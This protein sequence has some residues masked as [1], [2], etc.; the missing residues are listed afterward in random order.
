M[1]ISAYLTDH[2]G[3][4]VLLIGMG[5]LLH[6][7]IHLERRM[8][9]RMSTTCA[10]LF[11]YSV[12]CYVETYL[13]NQIDYS[14]WRPILSAVNYSLVTFVLVNI[15]LIVC[16]SQRLYLYIPA[17]L[18]SILCFVSIPTGI[19]FYISPDNHFGRGTLGYLTYFINALYLLYLIFSMFR[20]S[21]NTREDYPL[22]LFMAVTSVLC[23]IMPL[24]IESASQHWFNISIAIDVLLYYVFLLQQFTKRD[25]LTKLLNRQSYYSDSEKYD[26]EITS[27]VAIDMDGLKEI[28]DTEGHVAGDTALKALADCFMKATKRGQRAY[29][30]GGDEY[31]ILCLDTMEDAV[32]EL[33]ERIRN[34]VVKTPYTCSIGYAMKDGETSIDKLYQLADIKLYDE[35]KL[36]YERTGKI[37]R[38][39]K[40]P[41][42]TE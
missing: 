24:F 7:D 23:L 14:I 10:L 38:S 33:I 12:S 17:L 1:S 36:F 2:W 9:L 19:V 3:L 11:L 6:S 35:K 39:M 27:V 16:P 29:R 25:P 30:I 28:N 20:N 42:E 15:I 13:G 4:L 37:R 40:P 32:R 31:V 41:T 26:E 22:M 21:K 5:M 8:I 34:E 18:N